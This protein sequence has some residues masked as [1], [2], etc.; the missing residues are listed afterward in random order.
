MNRVEESLI[1]NFN[2]TEGGAGTYYVSY[3]LYDT[4]PP[5]PWQTHNQ[6]YI[7]YSRPYSFLSS[8][9]WPG[10]PANQSDMWAIGSPDGIYDK[11]KGYYTQPCVVGGWNN[12]L[13]D[14]KCEWKY[15]TIVMCEFPTE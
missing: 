13:A 1:P 9:H 10:H 14:S 4:Q 8:N 3:V 6:L 7:S 5:Q 15:P 2:Q 12:G 11:S